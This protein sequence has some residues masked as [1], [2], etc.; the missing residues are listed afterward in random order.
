MFDC[1]FINIKLE[2]MFAYLLDSTSIIEVFYYKYMYA[3]LHNNIIIHQCSFIENLT[4]IFK[5]NAGIVKTNVK[6][7]PII[8]TTMKAIIAK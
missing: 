8:V 4:Q 6:G 5:H 2:Q 3:V 1:V 7:V